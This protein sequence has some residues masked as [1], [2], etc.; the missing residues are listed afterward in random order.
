MLRR[1][2]SRRR[3]PADGSTD[4][5]LR[6]LVADHA[7]AVYRV[8]LSIVRDPALAEDVVQETLIKAW[9]H[10]D[11]VREPGSERAWVLRIGHNTAVSVRRLVPDEAT[12]PDLLPDRPDPRDPARYVQSRGELAALREALDHLDELSRTILVLRDIEELS[13]QQIADALGLPLPTVKTRL[14]RA[15]RE[16]QRIAQVG[17]HA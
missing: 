8:A 2:R 14:L 9:Q 3:A 17:E 5:R 16:L 15:R 1:T 10:L 12:D 6:A 11:D 4:Q 7:A 13:Y